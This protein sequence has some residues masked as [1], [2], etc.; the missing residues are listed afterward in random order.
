[1][2]NTPE[3]QIYDLFN[4]LDEL[5]KNN[6]D[7]DLQK[8]IETRLA[9]SK[10][11]NNPTILDDKYDNLEK[12]EKSYHCKCCG[13]TTTHLGKFKKHIGHNLDDEDKIKSKHYKIYYTT[14]LMGKGFYYNTTDKLFV[15]NEGV[16]KTFKTFSKF[17]RYLKGIYQQ[18]DYEN[19]FK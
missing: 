14:Y 5:V 8:M 17:K 11:L 10:K 1:M 4:L 15:H 13:Y 12:I 2:T 3:Y 18:N 6:K 19:L 9:Q 7:E 16:T